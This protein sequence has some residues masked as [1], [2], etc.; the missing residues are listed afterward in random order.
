MI[1]SL[2]VS[3]ALVFSCS[4]ANAATL[5]V[6]TPENLNGYPFSPSF[7]LDSP[8]YQQVWDSDVF[9]SLGV[10]KI[11][12]ISFEIPLGP[13]TIT[14]WT[15]IATFELSFSTTSKAVNE[16]DTS[17]TSAGFEDN[18]GA[19]ASPFNQ[20]I[21]NREIL[22]E[23]P[24]FLGEFVYDPSKGNLLLDISV[25]GGSSGF[26]FFVRATSNSNGLFSRS[27]NGGVGYENYGAIVTFDYDV[28]VDDL[29]MSAVP[30]PAASLLLI[31]GLGAF[32][33]V[34]R[35]KT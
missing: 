33:V 4:Q 14:S 26:G 5:T 11:N 22:T 2:L 3:I 29:H 16:L 34:G 12:A 30:L 21:F 13:N 20:T 1:K 24:E 18:I 31:M 32:G 9:S 8:R 10:I 28:V 23:N 35:R 7:A 6:G 15:P 19:D 25:P 27:Y 17:G